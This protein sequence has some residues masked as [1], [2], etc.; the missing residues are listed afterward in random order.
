MNL[1]LLTTFHF[2]GGSAPAP[3]P[4]GGAPP[5]PPPVAAPAPVTSGGGDASGRSAL[6]D[7]LNRGSDV[8]AGN[9][10]PFSWSSQLAGSLTHQQ[11]QTIGL[12]KVTND[13]KTH[14]NP[15]LRGSSKVPATSGPVKSGPSSAYAPK[16]FQASKPGSSVTR[17]VSVKKPPKKELLGQKKWVV[18]G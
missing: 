10:F 16:P 2:Q 13:M 15:A 17:P 9:H 8:T 6:L 11:S 14:K 4:P 12:K 7:A 1:L 18:V 3:P 5:P